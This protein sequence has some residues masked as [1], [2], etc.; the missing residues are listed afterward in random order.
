MKSSR[1]EW[2]TP[3]W[4]QLQGCDKYKWWG[5]RA[6]HPTLPQMD[7]HPMAPFL[8][9]PSPSIMTSPSYFLTLSL[10]IHQFNNNLLFLK[11]CVG[12]HNNFCCTLLI[13]YCTLSFKVQHIMPK[14]HPSYMQVH[15]KFIIKLWVPKKFTEIIVN[16][17][18][19]YIIIKSY[20]G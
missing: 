20:I 19:S 18:F 5:K 11:L 12:S 7:I 13:K 8:P 1:R 9:S 15:C 16:V 2:C 14:S 6:G 10:R 3:R 4:R 17:T